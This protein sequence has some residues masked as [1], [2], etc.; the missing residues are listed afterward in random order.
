M[1]KTTTETQGNKTKTENCV[2]YISELEATVNNTSG[3]NKTH[4][5]IIS[6]L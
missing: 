3:S 5:I 2:N 1:K 4:S 6:K